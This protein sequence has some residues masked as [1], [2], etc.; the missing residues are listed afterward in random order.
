M[1]PRTPKE[2]E[3]AY[4][5]IYEAQTGGVFKWEDLTVSGRRMWSPAYDRILATFP[6]MWNDLA[7]AGYPVL[8]APKGEK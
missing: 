6:S 2:R 1:T 3:R 7:A 8:I 4:K 5:T